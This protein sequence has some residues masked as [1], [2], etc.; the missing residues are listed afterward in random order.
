MSDPK[1]TQFAKII[2]QHSTRVQPGDKVAIRGF[3][4]TA[5]ATPLINAVTEQVLIAGGH[6]HLLI[7]P[8]EYRELLYH[9][10]SEEQLSYIDPFVQ[11]IME[12]FD[13]DIRITSAG[14]TKAL[15]GVDPDRLNIIRSTYYDLLQ[16]WFQRS[17]EG[18]LRWLTTRFPTSAY[19]QEAEMSL[20]EY[21][22]FFY[23]SCF[24]DL[25]DPIG[26][27]EKMAAKQDEI[28]KRFQGGEELVFS[29]PDIDLSL[30][31]KD[32]AFI[33]CIG[34][35]NLPDGEIFCGPVEESAEGWVRFSFPCIYLGTEVEGV[36]LE[37]KSGKV[38]GARAAKNEEYLRKTIEVDE[39]ASR[40]GEFGI[41]LNTAIDR[42]TGS[43][44]FDEKIAGTIHF[45]LGAGY[46]ESGSINK[47]SIHWDMLVDMREDSQIELD[48]NLIYAD[49]RFVR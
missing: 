46:P 34:D 4:L 11:M 41:G 13:V 3:P 33:P 48:G 28:V 43:M 31:I 38:V 14:N 30:S 6:P 49:G 29:G 32:R 12:D 5:A 45:A 44:L 42:F 40:L 15:S 39:G 10:A 24:A 18:K 9:S 23:S 2:V 36:E 20:Q 19:A 35:N 16:T 1:I 8:P 25:D 47:S 21:E 22:Q 17:A 26:A 27:F 37:F 7:T